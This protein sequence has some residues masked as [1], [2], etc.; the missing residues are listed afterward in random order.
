[1]IH[2]S[3]GQYPGY[4][5]NSIAYKQIT[6]TKDL[7]RNLANEDTQKANS[8]VKGNSTS[9]IIREM[10]TNFTMRHH[11]STNVSLLKSK[12]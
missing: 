11:A 8:Y 3:R 10:Q 2:L 12:R 9:L 5:R 7:I 4:I 6:W 1:M